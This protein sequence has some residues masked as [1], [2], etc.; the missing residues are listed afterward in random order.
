MMLACDPT[1]P[2]PM[3]TLTVRRLLIDLEEPFARRWNGGDAFRSAF[4]NALS[5]SFPAGEQFFIDAVRAGVKALPP[6][7]QVQFAQEMQGF[8]GQEATHRRIHALFNAQLARQGHVN[9]WEARILRRMKRL[10][11]A[12]PRHGVGI[13]A[14]TEHFTAIFAE[15]LLATPQVL[16]G[17]EPRLRTLWQWHAAEESEHRSTA[18]DLYRALGGNELWRRRWMRVVALFF[19]TDLLRQTLR[20]LWHDGAVLHLQT[21]RSAGE[22]LFGR[23]GL[24]RQTCPAWRAYFRA[25]FHPSSQGGDL[26]ARWL[27]ENATHVELVGHPS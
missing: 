9:A 27:R 24:V 20:N 14:A 1:S 3:A 12:D 10:Q 16:A 6:P 23:E 2:G 25:G 26:G 15:H 5:M 21:W 22:F 19:A 11:G 17:A 8:I 18:F 13:T 4:F 7:R